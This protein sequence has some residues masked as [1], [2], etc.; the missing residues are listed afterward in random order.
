MPMVALQS[1]HARIVGALATS[2]FRARTL[3]ASVLKEFSSFFASAA[4]I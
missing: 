3:T 2:R 4:M 1:K